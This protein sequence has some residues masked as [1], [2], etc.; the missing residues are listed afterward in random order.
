M[1]C[2]LGGLVFTLSL[3]DGLSIRSAL[4]WDRGHFTSVFGETK[5]QANPIVCAICELS[6]K[7]T[8]CFECFFKEREKKQQ[9]AR[10]CAPAEL[11]TRTAR[12]PASGRRKG[13][14]QPD[15]LGETPTCDTKFHRRRRTQWNSTLEI[16]HKND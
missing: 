1:L 14:L 7:I 15:S 9:A 12:L 5:H 10:V 3:S 4:T 2:I 6:G 16:I 13:E 8:L 11:N